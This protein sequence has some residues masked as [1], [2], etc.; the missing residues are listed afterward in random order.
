MTLVGQFMLEG[1]YGVLYVALQ[2][3]SL[4][5]LQRGMDMIIVFAK[6]DVSNA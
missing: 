6:M 5:R 1:K 2:S 3:I 4:L